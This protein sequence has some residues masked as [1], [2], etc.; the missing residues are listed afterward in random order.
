MSEPGTASGT[1][2]LVSSYVCFYLGLT[3]VNRLLTGQWTYPVIDDA[4]KAMGILGVA[5][6]IGVAIAGCVSL[7]FA[8]NWLVVASS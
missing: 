4:H 5:L 2:L 3:M 7:G 8:G 1:R 6:V